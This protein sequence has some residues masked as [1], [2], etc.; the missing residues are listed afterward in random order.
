MLLS[1]CGSGGNKPTFIIISGENESVA[2][3]TES[4]LSQQH[5]SSSRDNAKSQSYTICP[6]CNGT[7]VFEFMPGDVR[8]PRYTC[9][10]C[11][12]KGRVTMEEA[13]KLMELQQEVN[14]M[15]GGYSGNNYGGTYGNNY[16]DGRRQCPIC[17]G[18]GRCSM[19][20]G[21]GEWNYNGM[22]GQPGGRMD[23]SGCHGTGRCQT[24]Y[25]RGTI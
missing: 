16:N 17:Y 11:N 24:C 13:M 18:N 10:G 20:A 3:N 6:M 25:G 15:M 8:A 4:Q 1:A 12:G 14:A 21:R 19:C 22:Y 23:C 2:E 9:T 5:S 7:G